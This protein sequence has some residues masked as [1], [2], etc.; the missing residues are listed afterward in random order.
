MQLIYDHNGITVHVFCNPLVV[1]E[2]DD[3]TP[4]P[5]LPDDKKPSEYLDLF[6]K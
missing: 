1:S 3:H 6:F 2:D 4:L 5:P